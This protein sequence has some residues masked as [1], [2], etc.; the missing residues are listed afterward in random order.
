MQHDTARAPRTAGRVLHRARWY[1]LMDRLVPFG[2][3]I[4]ETLAEIAALAPGE[5]VLDV[6]CGT[7]AL[8]VRLAAGVGGGEVHGIDASPEMVEVAKG[9]AARAGARV[10]LQVAVVEALPFPDASFDLVTSSL[11]LHHLPDDVKRQGLA[12]VRRVLKPGGRFVAVDFAGGSHSLLG[13]VLSFLGHM[14]GDTAVE[15]TSML[16]NSGFREVEVIPTRHRSF[17]FLRAR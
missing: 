12:Q 14:H 15:L 13:H 4:R 10:E 16:R 5:R 6:G 1:D 7:G 2:R 9:K 11:M 17:A 8:A 3:A